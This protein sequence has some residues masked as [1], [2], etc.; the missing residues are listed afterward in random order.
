M[1][2]CNPFR[3]AALLAIL[4]TLQMPLA[5]AE[6]WPTRSITLLIPFGAG[7]GI[8]VIGRSFAEYAG[9][10]LG[11]TV[12]VENRQGGGGIVAGISLSK[13]PPD[14]YT[15]MLQAIG[16][17]VLRPLMDSAAGFDPDKDF[18]PIVLVSETPNVILGGPAVGDKSLREAVDWARQKADGITIAHPGVGTMGHLA[19]ILL[20]SDAKF[21]ASFIAYRA[22]GQA[23]PD[24][25]SGRIDLG[26]FAYTP[27]VK[28]ARIVAVMT[29]DPVDFLPG[30]PSMKQA[31]VPGVYA[32]TWYALYGPPKL[33]EDIVARIA[34]IVNKYLQ[35]EDGRTRMAQLGA[36]GL[37]GTPDEL[38]KRMAQDKIVWDKVIKGAN[39]KFSDQQ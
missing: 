12:V 31:G 36:R 16:P 20:A 19:A 9:K 22:S 35:S 15:I 6:T 13:L 24:L 29:E 3:L 34:G 23:L 30:V 28:S 5:R 14:G 32:S 27:Q 17:M 26:V 8:D 7:S 21:G 18:T 39:I 11:Q 37:G 33:P 4:C 25:L 2:G 10:E 38:V 1:I